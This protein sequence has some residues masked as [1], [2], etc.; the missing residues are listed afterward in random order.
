MPTAERVV[1]P[2][3]HC[4]AASYMSRE[5]YLKAAGKTV[6]CPHC[7]QPCV[8]GVAGAVTAPEPVQPPP[9]ASA[10]IQL[11]TSSRNAP[12]TANGKKAKPKVKSA[13][14]S[15]KWIMVWV[16]SLWIVMMP[17]LALQGHR[18]M[19]Y[20]AKLT[21]EKDA[22]IQNGERIAKPVLELAAATTALWRGLIVPGCVYLVAM[23]F[24][25]V[26]CFALTPERE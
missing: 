16:T 11:D 14:Q 25:G 21:A 2:C 9:T 12:G 3:P 4:N 7:R 17:L 26:V 22:Y 23:I 6:E 15:V 10:P 5:A 1:I 20:G 19:M 8:L 18:S 13:R 24:L